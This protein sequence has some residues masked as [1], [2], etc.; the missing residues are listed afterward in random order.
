MCLMLALVQ[1]M[2]LPKLYEYSASRPAFPP[3]RTTLGW[4]S[5][6]VRELGVA[7]YAPLEKREFVGLILRVSLLPS[8]E[9]WA[10]R[11]HTTTLSL[12]LVVSRLGPGEEGMGSGMEE[13]LTGRGGRADMRGIFVGCAAALRRSCSVD[14]FFADRGVGTSRELTTLRRGVEGAESTML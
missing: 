10:H 13:E 3:R 9:W 2:S 14:R 1:S 6:R 11:M 12:L 4:L 8:L 7:S 5:V